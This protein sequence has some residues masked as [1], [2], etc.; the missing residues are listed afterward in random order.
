MDSS[1]ADGHRNG[2]K[3]NDSE[4]SERERAGR[5]QKRYIAVA[6]ILGLLL[7]VLGFCAGK[8]MR[9]KHDA[10]SCAVS[11]QV[12]DVGVCAAAPGGPCALQIG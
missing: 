4:K 1:D 6:L 11:R 8:Q 9:Q 5:T 2:C 3:E 10:A 12:S 7:A